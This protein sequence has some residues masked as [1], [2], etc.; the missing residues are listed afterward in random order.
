MGRVGSWHKEMEKV[1][2][3]AETSIEKEEKRER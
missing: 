2:A 1:D 3:A